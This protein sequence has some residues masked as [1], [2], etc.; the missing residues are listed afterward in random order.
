LPRRCRFSSEGRREIRCSGR[1]GD[2]WN[3]QELFQTA[4]AAENRGNRGRA[5]KAYRAI[6][7]K[8]PKDT[9]AAGAAFR[10]A[11]MLEQNGDYIKAATAYRNYAEKYPRSPNFDEA[12]EAQFR[13]GEMYLNG[14][15]VKLLGIP[16][17][18]AIDKSLGIFAGIVRSAPYGKY[19]ARAQLFILNLFE[20]Y[21][22]FI[23]KF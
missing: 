7:R 15:K 20:Y 5:A 21:L 18:S 2:Q 4:Q 6:L 12:I 22:N 14:K 3:A 1:R 13:I 19:T 11:V 17:K 23:R 10:Y 8:Y 16:V 9:L